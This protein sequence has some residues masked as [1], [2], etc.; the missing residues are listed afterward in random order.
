MTEEDKE[1]EILKAKRLAEMEKNLAEQNNQQEH[2]TMLSNSSQN[3]LLPRDQIIKKL[4][5]RGLEVLSN[6]ESQ[7]PNETKLVVEKLAELIQSGE[8]DEVLDGGKLLTLFRSV[9]ISVRMENKIN[10]EKDGKFVSISEKFVK[11]TDDS[12]F[13]DDEI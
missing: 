11:Q 5:Y 1:L 4:G 2:E 3:K 8:I 7:F 10:V 12:S 13:E 6:A 9:G